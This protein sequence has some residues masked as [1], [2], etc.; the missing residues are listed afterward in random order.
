MTA[1]AL[2][3]AV[4]YFLVCGIAMLN[5]KRR[6]RGKSIYEGLDDDETSSLD[7]YDTDSITPGERVEAVSPVAS[8]ESLE[9]RYD[10]MT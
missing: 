3:M 5:D 10:D 2:A 1:L 6:N 4:L 7:D 9:R 8:A